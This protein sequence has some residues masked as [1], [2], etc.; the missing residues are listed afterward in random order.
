MADNIPRYHI[1]NTTPLA[2]RINANDTA[3]QIPYLH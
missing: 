3:N 1:N 2:Y